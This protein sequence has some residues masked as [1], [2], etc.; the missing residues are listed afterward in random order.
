M[1]R[2][3]HRQVNIVGNKKRGDFLLFFC[4]HIP[5]NSDSLHFIGECDNMEFT[6][7]SLVNAS[8]VN[9]GSGAIY[10]TTMTGPN[11]QPTELFSSGMQYP[12]KKLTCLFAKLIWSISSFSS[13]A[14]VGP[15]IDSATG[16][17]LQPA[18]AY[19]TLPAQYSIYT[20][21]AI[22]SHLPTTTLIPGTMASPGKEGQLR[23]VRVESQ[24]VSDRRTLSWT[25]VFSRSVRNEL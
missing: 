22:Y 6:H 12:S 18:T 16:L 4:K 25:E 19:T 3:H 8:P 24:S 11:G 17:Q 23:D 13:V 5:F 9:N 20:P 10:Q 21:T 1:E 14:V 7:C 15:A 2:W